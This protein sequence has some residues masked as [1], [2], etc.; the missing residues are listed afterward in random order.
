M[1]LEAPLQFVTRHTRVV[2]RT[3]ILTSL[4]FAHE[5]HVL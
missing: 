5:V 1:D 3:A 4:E 2:A